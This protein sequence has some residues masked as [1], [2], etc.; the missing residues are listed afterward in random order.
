MIFN[1]CAQL[2]LVVNDQPYMHC[3]ATVPHWTANYQGFYV[4]YHMHANT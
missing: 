1:I 3:L 2:N 4:C